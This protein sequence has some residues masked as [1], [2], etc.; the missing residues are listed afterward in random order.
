MS[1]PLEPSDGLNRRAA[2][3]MAIVAVLVALLNV[4]RFV[5][6]KAGPLRAHDLA[7]STVTIT[8]AGGE[9][10][11]SAL[12][13]PWDGSQ[14][15]GF[16]RLASA[17][18]PQTLWALTGAAVATERVLPVLF[19]ILQIVMA[20][21]AFLFVR[22]FLRCSHES[23][24]AGA[25]LSLVL[26]HFF[27][28]H[29]VVTSAILLAPLAGYL[30]VPASSL[31]WRALQV[32]GAVLVMT[33]SNPTSTLFAM[34]LGHLALIALAPRGS[35]TRHLALFVGFWLAYAIY[36]APTVVIQLQEFANS[37]R[38]LYRPA[39][40]GLS[41]LANLTS[42]LLNP[43]VIS[44]AAVFVILVD[45]RTWRQTVLFLL[46]VVGGVALAAAN[47]ILVGS[48]MAQR[49]P[50]LLAI[51]T[52]Y[53]RM[54]Y[55]VPV[56]V[57]VWA[58]WL[59]KYDER[60]R[61]R[62]L[63][64]RALALAA[65]CLLIARPLAH[66]NWAT[67]TV[68]EPYWRYA[69]VLGVSMGFGL[70]WWA[71][72]AWTMAIVAAAVVLCVRYQYTKTWEVPFQGNLF[73]EEATLGQPAG[74]SRSVTVMR[75]CDWVDLFPAQARAAGVETLDG[76]A[77]FYDR[78]F[79]ERW[80]YFVADNP[81]LCT[82]RYASWPTR[83]ELTV[84]G[85]R[86]ASDRILPWLWINNVEFVRA[87][88]PLD[89]PELQLVDQRTFTYDRVQRVTRYLY[90]VRNPVGRVF[91]LPDDIARR[92]ASADFSIE[93]SALAAL[94]TQG[95]VSNVL[96]ES[97]DGSHLRFSGAFEPGR[98]VVASINYHRGWRLRIDGALSQVPIEPG[99]F[100]MLAFHPPGGHHDYQLEFAS[101][102]TVVV[103]IG[104]LTAVG[105]LCVLTAPGLARR[106]ELQRAVPSWLVASVL[107]A[108]VVVLAGAVAWR[109]ASGST[110]AWIAEP[111]AHRM[112][113]HT[114]GAG[115][116]APIRNFPLR[117]ERTAADARFW[118]AIQPYG[119]NIRFADASGRLLPFEIEE[120]DRTR[121]RLVAW[122]RIAELT[123]G[124][125]TAAYLYYGN[126]D[127][128]AA[129]NAEPVWDADYEAVW[130]LNPRASARNAV[131]ADSSGHGYDGILRG[132]QASAEDM[133]D[134]I[135][136]E[137]KTAA[138]EVAD[139]PG[140]QSSR[141]DWTV[142]FLIRPAP[143][144]KRN[145]GL[146]QHGS[147]GVF[148]L[149]LH[150]GGF[151]VLERR[152]GGTTT[153][154]S[155]SREQIP[156]SEWTAVTLSRTRHHLR[157]ALNGVAQSAYRVTPDFT[158]GAQTAPLRFGVGPHGSLDGRLAEVRI[159]RGLARSADWVLASFRSRSG[160]FTQMGAPESR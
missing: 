24:V 112:A 66:T 42:M 68:F 147:A 16:P 122:V 111:W 69:L 86:Y 17:Q 49:F 41:Y 143:L 141:G 159:T 160:S 98:T 32:G 90:R 113:V 134:G 18:H 99:P 11:R 80:R 72:R 12:G 27:H 51:S 6:G 96:A 1:D 15:R 26:F 93:E 107:V 119:N 146:L 135:S 158:D 77:N 115:Q 85:L 120:F 40:G 46:L 50:L 60:P 117:I 92:A 38:S 4:D 48:E 57:L 104:M 7:D 19:T 56:A 63:I 55:F 58:T 81:A 21:G 2:V 84:A 87:P 149:Y 105:L 118:S 114:Q 97:V 157:L 136:F 156:S 39:P 137:R 44:P 76:I 102:A 139:W 25:V 116:T 88:E 110:A 14:L 75:G 123:V 124:P 53:Y 52:M 10:W 142:E 144:D 78:G 45:R 129:V 151:L 3:A 62:V 29:P 30:S 61:R 126:R 91:T 8:A 59:W 100:G 37:S 31:G 13:S 73:L 82:A 47:Q 79:V 9:I 121:Q 54:Y 103:P 140:L 83:A 33:L 108:A 125:Q 74:F 128:P 106:L 89:Y 132:A 28:E 65:F 101:A 153:E 70:S 64:W 152:N 154:T 148:H 95:G 109:R 35:R 138:I 131:I 20:V 71:R 94:V 43:A 130:H 34:P 23:A 5:L 133:A 67:A 22:S 36:Y 127:A 155:L 150:N 145:F